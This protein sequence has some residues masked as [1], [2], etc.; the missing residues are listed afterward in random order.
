[1][2]VLL[3]IEYDGT[4]F[5][6]WQIQPGKR[7]VQGELTAALSSL[8][9][10]DVVLHGSGRT[11]AGV[12]A[13]GQKA[14]FDWNEPSETFPVE[15]LP[16]AANTKLPPD[17]CVKDAVVVDETFEAQY[18][19]KRK[20]YR[21]SFYLSRTNRPLFDRYA[22][23]VAYA[24]EKFDS[25]RARKGLSYLVGEHDFIAFSSTGSS[26]KTSVRTIYDAT[27]TKQENGVWALTITG[28]GFLYNMVRIIAGTI[29]EI[30]LGLR[31]ADYVQDALTTGRRTWCGKTFPAR[32][33]TLL[34]VEYD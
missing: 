27:L 34:S 28:N 4:D 12:H 18:S 25:E 22:A 20:T 31:P 7:T 5:F 13:L 23:Q 17:V 8:L 26:V 9:G 11:D 15:R 10:Q 33:L 14:H 16:L 2:R 29:V 1:M 30:G 19:A 6:G 3:T 24:E 21:Y 32:G